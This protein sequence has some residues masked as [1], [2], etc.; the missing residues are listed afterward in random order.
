VQWSSDWVRDLICIMKMVEQV[1]SELAQAEQ[2]SEPIVIRLSGHVQQNDRLAMR[3]IARQLVQQTGGTFLDPSADDEPDADETD[4]IEDAEENPFLGGYKAD[5]SAPAVSVRLPPTAHLPSLISTLPTLGRPVIVVLDGFDLFALHARQALLYCLLDTVQHSQAAANG[6]NYQPEQSASPSK[7]KRT[8][9]ATDGDVDIPK[10]AGP[11]S[12]SGLAVVGVSTRVDTLEL[13]EKRVKSRF[14]GRILRTAAPG[15]WE[16]W[17]NLLHRALG[18][19]L[20]ESASEK[21][22]SSIFTQWADM[23]G[24]AVDKF[25]QDNAVNDV[26]RESVAL[27][28]DMR[29]VSRILVRRILYC[30]SLGLTLV[31]GRND[32]RPEP[33]TAVADSCWL[34]QGR[35]RSALPGQIRGPT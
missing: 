34:E 1:L 16:T 25:L 19:Q 9:K 11:T 10:D 17:S 35:H 14:S 21:E 3:E 32:D 29:L 2:V 23:W 24:T 7:G 4:V 5:D 28:K 22:D 30:D 12:W 15:K 33:R 13:L 8:A 20:P 18:I 26:F 27:I 6:A 31:V